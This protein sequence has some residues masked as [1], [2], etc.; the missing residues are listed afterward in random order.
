MMCK[1]TAKVRPCVGRQQWPGKEGLI[2]TM[3]NRIGNV[4]LLSIAT[5]W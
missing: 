4:G 3:V 5:D 2:S 1:L